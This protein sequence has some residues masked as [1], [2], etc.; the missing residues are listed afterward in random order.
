MTVNEKSLRQTKVSKQM[1]VLLG[2][3]FLLKHSVACAFAKKMGLN[4]LQPPV[5][6]PVS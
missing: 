4:L 6:R 2:A 3:A 5:Y 1:N